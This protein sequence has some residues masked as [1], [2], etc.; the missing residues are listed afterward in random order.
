[1][2]NDGKEALARVEKENFDLILMDVQ[3]PGMDGLEATNLIRSREIG[4]GRHTPIIAMTAYAM[5]GDRE[6]CLESG[7]DR[8]V[9][10][11]IRSEELYAA[12][13][14]AIPGGV[15][16][17]AQ[18]RNGPPPLPQLVDWQTALS[19]VGGDEELLRELAATFLAQCPQWQADLAAAL[20]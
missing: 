16:R 14:E 17:A 11:P 20:K 12:I 1:I 5:K 3:M 19:Y 8:Y 10:K 18:E 9:T 13:R 15:R 4:T 2:A 6:A 7:M